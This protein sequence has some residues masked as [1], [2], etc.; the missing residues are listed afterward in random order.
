[1]T[2]SHA[3]EQFFS[4]RFKVDI[5]KDGKAAEEM[6]MNNPLDIFEDY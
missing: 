3:W 2:L 6:F 5:A 1:L 4:W